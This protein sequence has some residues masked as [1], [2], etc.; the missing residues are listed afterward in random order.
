MHL[1]E[2]LARLECEL[3]GKGDIPVMIGKCPL[4]QAHLYAGP[5]TRDGQKLVRLVIDCHDDDFCTYHDLKRY[6]AGDTLAALGIAPWYRRLAHG[7]RVYPFRTIGA[8]LHL[9]YQVRGVPTIVVSLALGAYIPFPLGQLVGLLGL[10]VGTLMFMW[11]MSRLS[12]HY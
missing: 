12:E 5:T 8:L 4:T 3:Q 10:G 9:A 6:L 7:L 2:L 11:G 1:T